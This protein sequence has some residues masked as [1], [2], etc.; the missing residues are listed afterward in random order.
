MVS[1]IKVTILI[2]LPIYAYTCGTQIYP[3]STFT[4]L[5]GF[6]GDAHLV[7]WPIPELVQTYLIGKTILYKY[8]LP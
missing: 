6:A 3:E 8:T 1:F 2:A 5:T 7:C 4:Y